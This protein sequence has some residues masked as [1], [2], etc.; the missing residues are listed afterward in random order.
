[1]QASFHAPRRDANGTFMKY[2]PFVFRVMNAHW[3]WYYGRNLKKQFKKFLGLG[4]KYVSYYGE[5]DMAGNIQTWDEYIKMAL[6]DDRY[7]EY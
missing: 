6:G 3:K 7:E 2:S 1:V 5:Y 4:Y